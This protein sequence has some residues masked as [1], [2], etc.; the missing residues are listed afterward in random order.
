MSGLV[1]EPI[2]VALCTTNRVQHGWLQLRRQ[3]WALE[4]GRRRI[5]F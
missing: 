5:T 1:C 3:I 2:I 4:N